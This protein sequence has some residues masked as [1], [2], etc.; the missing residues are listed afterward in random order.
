MEQFTAKFGTLQPN[1]P[2]GKRSLTNICFD[3]LQSFQRISSN[4]VFFFSYGFSVF[5]FFSFLLSYNIYLIYFYFYLFFFIH[6]FIY[7]FS[8][9]YLFIFFHSSIY[10]FF[11][12]HL[13]IYFF[14]FIY[15]FIFF[16][17]SIYLF[18]FIHL[19]MSFTLRGLNLPMNKFL[20]SKRHFLYST[21]KEMEKFLLM[22]LEL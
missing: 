19:F 21:R 13:F 4:M 12:I 3:V 14:S 7:F 18:F 2:F 20:S 10:L 5:F 11:F 6:L 15:L 1:P 22:S 8:F 9:I 16:H 17:S